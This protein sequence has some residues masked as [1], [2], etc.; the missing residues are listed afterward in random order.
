[1]TETLEVTAGSGLANL[2]LNEG[3]FEILIKI[4]SAH[5]VFNWSVLKKVL[6]AYC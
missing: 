3:V 4:S 6:G 2:Q 5:I 1:M